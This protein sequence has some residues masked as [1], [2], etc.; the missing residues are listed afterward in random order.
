MIRTAC[1]KIQRLPQQTLLAM[2]EN[3]AAY[4]LL[5]SLDT[6][7]WEIISFN[8]LKREVCIDI[9]TS[10]SSSITTEINALRALISVLGNT[11]EDNLSRL[12]YEAE[13][14]NL[15]NKIDYSRKRRISVTIPDYGDGFF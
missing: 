1:Q 15:Q 13:I 6:D 10:V 5:D 2:L 4:T 12:V 14:R 3:T 8:P 9:L 11:E 7:D